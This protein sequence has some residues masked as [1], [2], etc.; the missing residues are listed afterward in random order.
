MFEGIL[1]FLMTIAIIY[2][3]VQKMKQ[4]ELEEE[5]YDM[6]KREAIYEDKLDF[7]EEIVDKTDLLTGNPYTALR[8]IKETINSDKTIK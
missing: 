2:V 8:R 1:A 5:F 6:Q 3:A 7:I 4:H